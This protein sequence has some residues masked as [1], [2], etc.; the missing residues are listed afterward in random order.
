VSSTYRVLYLSHTPALVAAEFPNRAEAEDA[1]TA[2]LDDHPGCDLMIG[3]YSYPLVELGCPA[4]TTH[5]AR[6]H[7]C[8]GHTTTTWADAALL[9]LLV[10]AY[11]H[12]VSSPLRKYASDYTFRCWSP[13][14]LNALLV[15]LAITTE[16]GTRS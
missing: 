2:G 5:P 14:R 3:R 6:A 15:E 10:H 7:L 9:G 11:R 1:A 4:T 8:A 16:D 12:P 13:E